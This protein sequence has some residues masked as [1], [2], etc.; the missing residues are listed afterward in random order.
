MSYIGNKGQRLAKDGYPAA[1]LDDG[2]K[3]DR[4]D[5]LFLGQEARV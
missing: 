2:A 4:L 1:L 3:L 5:A